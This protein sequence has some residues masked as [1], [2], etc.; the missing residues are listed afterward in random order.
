MWDASRS[1]SSANLEHGREH[2]AL[3]FLL[4]PGRLR[5][6]A[7]P[8]KSSPNTASRLTTDRRCETATYDSG[9]LTPTL[10]PAASIDLVPVQGSFNLP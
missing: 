2:R 5:D 10:F 7:T 1:G 4:V 9:S 3:P 6:L 8:V